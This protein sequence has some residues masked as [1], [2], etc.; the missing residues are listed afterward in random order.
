MMKPHK[1]H[2]FSKAD[3]GAEP[4]SHRAAKPRLDEF[5]CKALTKEEISSAVNQS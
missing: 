2:I 1:P 3:G 5:L 4:A